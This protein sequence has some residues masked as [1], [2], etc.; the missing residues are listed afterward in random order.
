MKAKKIISL[1]VKYVDFIPEVAD[2]LEN[3]IYISK[4]FNT[5]SHL[6][7]CGCKNEVVTPIINEE[8]NGIGW[9]VTEGKHNPFMVSFAPSILNNHCPNKCHY[10][11]QYSKGVI[12]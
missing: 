5:A 11:I 3:I 12:F 6:C 9:I 7:L 1:S 8:L 10:V 4:K 2:M